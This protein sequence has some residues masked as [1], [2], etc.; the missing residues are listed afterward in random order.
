MDT[1]NNIVRNVMKRKNIEEDQASEL[2]NI[3]LAKRVK[4]ETPRAA[5]G[6]ERGETSQTSTAT[7]EQII[8][9]SNSQ[10]SQPSSS[11][12]TD[13]QLVADNT[14]LLQIPN[15]LVQVDNLSQNT[16]INASQTSFPQTLCDTPQSYVY[17]KH[18]DVMLNLALLADVEQN[19]NILFPLNVCAKQISDSSSRITVMMLP[20]KPCCRTIRFHH[21]HMQTLDM[22]EKLQS[23]FCQWAAA[24]PLVPFY[25]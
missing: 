11:S 1:D 21:P 7:S 15:S 6:T 3:L 17:M 8:N 4:M 23:Y 9:T 14:H 13:I 5:E 25:G 19:Y 12:G 2:V 22:Y 16:S 20:S 24:H 10:G 18:G